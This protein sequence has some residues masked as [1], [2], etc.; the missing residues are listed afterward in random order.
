MA[1]ALHKGIFACAGVALLGGGLAGIGLAN[2]T[3]TGAFDFYK[4]RPPTTYNMAAT[5]DSAGYYPVSPA[6]ATPPYPEN[7]TPLTAIPAPRSPEPA[8]YRPAARTD[9]EPVP[10]EAPAAL[11]EPVSVIPAQQ[12]SWAEPGDEAPA[13]PETEPAADDP[14]S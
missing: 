3:R 8:D 11:S 10:A 1:T 9:P 5:A 4:Q 13:T 7:P 6:A 14:A 12:G 2:Y